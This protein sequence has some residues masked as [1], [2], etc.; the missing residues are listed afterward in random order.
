MIK[1]MLLNLMPNLLQSDKQIVQILLT[2]PLLFKQIT[3]LKSK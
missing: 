2:E 3:Y 1:V